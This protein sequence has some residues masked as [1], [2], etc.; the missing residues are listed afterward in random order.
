MKD[1]GGGFEDERKVYDSRE[2]KQAD[3]QILK[4]KGSSYWRR[5][6]SALAS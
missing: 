6:K 1:D 4:H 2:S 5:G 3:G